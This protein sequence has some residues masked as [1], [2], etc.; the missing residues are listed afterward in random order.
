M[1]LRYRNSSDTS[2]AD[3]SA[4]L[5]KAF[6]GAVCSV[7]AAGCALAAFAPEPQTSG[8]DVKR[9]V[10]ENFVREAHTDA[11]MHPE[12]GERSGGKVSRETAQAPVAAKPD[13]TVPDAALL[14]VASYINRAYRIPVAQAEK[15]A[16]WAVEIGELRD[17][18]PLLILAVAATESS[19]NPKARSG[20]GAEGLMQVMTSVHHDK[21]E[22]FGGAPAAFEPYPN[23]AVGAEILDQLVRRTGSVTKALK[24][25]SGAALH[26]SD[27]GY[28]AK[29]LKERSRLVAAAGGDTQSAVRLARERKAGPAYKTGEVKSLLF[30]DWTRVADAARRAAA[31]ETTSALA[32]A[33]RSGFKTERGS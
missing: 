26:N 24:W 12:A 18:D 25:Y 10:E 13:A 32:D 28:G 1:H 29:V 5:K 27:F 14:G 20:A 21:F 4:F 17:L 3:R 22:A 7:I 16:Q 15:L 6:W 30:K 9:A 31:S 2:N 19:F 23:M 33:G 8:F 11:R